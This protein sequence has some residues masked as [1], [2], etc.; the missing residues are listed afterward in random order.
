MTTVE[1]DKSPTK[2]TKDE[3][4]KPDSGDEK[5]AEAAKDKLETPA[6]SKEGEEKASTSVS[7]DVTTKD[8]DGTVESVDDAA[9]KAAAAAKKANSDDDDPI[10]HVTFTVFTKDAY[11]KQCEK[12]AVEKKKEAEKGNLFQTAH[13]VDGELKYGNEDEEPDVE[14]K[15]TR[16]ANLV[17]GNILPDQCGIF[18][19]DYYGKPLEEIDKYIKSKVSLG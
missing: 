8:G 4:I 11:H 14:C 9:E 16:D 17:E 3:T 7:D 13:L 19:T 15:K 5:S 1:S 18:R 12:E 2:S 10:Q 6:N